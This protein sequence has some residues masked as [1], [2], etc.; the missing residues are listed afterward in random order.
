[1][2][3]AIEGSGCVSEEMEEGHEGGQKK[4]CTE[5]NM[6]ATDEATGGADK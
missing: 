5:W 3:K 1:V 2:H 4:L 6:C